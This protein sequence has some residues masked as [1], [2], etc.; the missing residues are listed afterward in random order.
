V[1]FIQPGEEPSRSDSGGRRELGW[2]ECHEL[3]RQ[4]SAS[5]R[6]SAGFTAVLLIGCVK[7]C[8]VRKGLK[9]T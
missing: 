7:G 8:P 4:V 3:R 1:H 2:E 6:V 5:G 9:E